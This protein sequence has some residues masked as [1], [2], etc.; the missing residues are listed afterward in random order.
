[1][2]AAELRVLVVDDDAGMRETLQDILAADGIASV[3]AATGAAAIAAFEQGG[4]SLALVDQRLPDVAGTDLAQQ[5]KGQDPDL[6]VFMLTGY[7]S[8]ETA[9]AADMNTGRSGS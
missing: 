6:P 7:A 8:T 9:M 2:T 4:I 3:T 5:L 1:M